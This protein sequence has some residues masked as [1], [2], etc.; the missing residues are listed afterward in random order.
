[1]F[2]AK[3]TSTGQD[4]FKTDRAGTKALHALS[5][6]AAIET[7]QNSLD[8]PSSDFTKQKTWLE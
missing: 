3:Q 2:R 5:L 1:M 4:N 8:L 7:G 6:Y